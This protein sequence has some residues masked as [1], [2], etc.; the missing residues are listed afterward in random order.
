MTWSHRHTIYVSNRQGIIAAPEQPQRRIAAR[1]LL[2]V[3]LLF[4]VTLI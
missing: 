1:F 3:K 4:Q 2:T